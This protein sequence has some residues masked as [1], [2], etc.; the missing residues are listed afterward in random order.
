LLERDEDGRY[1]IGL[2]LLDIA[3][4]ASR[5]VG[6]REAALPFLQDLYEAVE[7]VRATARG[8]SRRVARARLS[9]AAAYPL[10]SY[11]Q[12]A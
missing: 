9:G 10:L 2:L 11:C 3:T 4:S 1:R 6:L 8:I 5:A 12:F 7:V